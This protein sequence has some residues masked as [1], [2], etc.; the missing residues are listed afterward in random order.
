M[1]NYPNDPP[2]QN[3]AAQVAANEWHLSSGASI[4][5]VV[6]LPAVILLLLG[7]SWWLNRRRREVET[8]EQRLETRRR[9]LE[10]RIQRL[11]E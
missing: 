5:V 8:R 9:A 11:R 7:L 4:A 2:Y 10:A 1:H 6:S 3:F